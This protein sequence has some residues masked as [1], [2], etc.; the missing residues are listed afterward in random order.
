MLI[1]PN[2]TRNR[3]R[4]GDVGGSLQLSDGQYHCSWLQYCSTGHGSNDLL[5]TVW[6]WYV[7]RYA[8]TNRVTQTMSSKVSLVIT[9]KQ[10][11]TVC[12]TYAKLPQFSGDL[13]GCPPRGERGVSPVY[14]VYILP[15]IN[16]PG[17]YNICIGSS[18]GL[19]NALRSAARPSSLLGV[20]TRDTVAL[21][22]A[23]MPQ[24]SC[25]VLL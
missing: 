2:W 4:N 14:F 24:Y 8:T 23:A 22:A 20:S 10:K 3:R 13:C 6:I 7:T 11:T 15:G 5:S 16:M 21:P 1:W 25:C 12:K 9:G 17:F 18:F 19:V